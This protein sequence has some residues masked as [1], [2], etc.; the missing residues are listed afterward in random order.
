M[1]RE[2]TNRRLLFFFV[3]ARAKLMDQAGKAL[4]CLYRKLRNITIPIDLQLKLFDTLIL[5]RGGSRISS[6]GRGELKK[7]A[8]SGGRRENFW[9]ISCEKS[10]FYA[11]KIIFFSI[12]GGHRVRPPPPLGSSPASNTIMAVKYGVMRTPTY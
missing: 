6:W 5:P 1:W 4:Y 8:P 9:G 10:R 11:K 3:K 7:I 12:L 2:F